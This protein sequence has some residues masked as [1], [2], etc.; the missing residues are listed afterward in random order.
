MR[1]RGIICA[2]HPLQVTAWVVKLL[3]LVQFI[4]W[5]LPGIPLPLAFSLPLVALPLFLIFLVIAGTGF[6]LM[7]TDPTSPNLARK[8]KGKDI[9]DSEVRTTAACLRGRVFSGV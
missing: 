3:Y 5:V 6:Y 1:T 4:F 9:I 2:W 7:G 8:L